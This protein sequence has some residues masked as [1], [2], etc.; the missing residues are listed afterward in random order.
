M[1]SDSRF[2]ALEPTPPHTLAFE[3]DACP[4]QPPESDRVSI[5]SPLLPPR[6]F[7][8]TQPYARDEKATGYSEDE[9]VEEDEFEEDYGDPALRLYIESSLEEFVVER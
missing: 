5:S 4:S 9:N 3:L 6:H 7:G 8:E 1:N 2:S